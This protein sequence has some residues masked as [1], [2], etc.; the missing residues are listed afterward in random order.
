M[1]TLSE[2]T[3]DSDS[4]FNICTLEAVSFSKEKLLDRIHKD[5][6]VI[7]VTNDEVISDHPKRY[8]INSYYEI[9]SVIV[10]S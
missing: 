3:L 4:Y 9:N 6:L 10:I 8:E 1:Y 2:I 5:Y 7:D